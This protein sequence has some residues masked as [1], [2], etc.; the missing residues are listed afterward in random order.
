MRW[1]IS[2][3]VILVW[4]SA[5]VL[6]VGGCSMSTPPTDTEI[7]KAIDESG[8]LMGKGFTV[9]SPVVVVEKGPRKQD[10]SWPVKV[11]VTMTMQLPNGK[12]SE[13]RENT[14]MFRVFK[15]PDNAGR[16]VW[17]AALGS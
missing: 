4:I 9:T 12:M 17:K 15:A 16:S 3:L 2:L 11:K 10:G 14:P 7:L 8:I 5:S 1:K 13:P 6:S